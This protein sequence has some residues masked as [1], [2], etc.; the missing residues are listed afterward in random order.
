MRGGSRGEGGGGA[1]ENNPLTQACAR[2]IERARGCECTWDSGARGHTC[3]ELTLGIGSHAV[4]NGQDGAGPAVG[5]LA[6][7]AA[8]RRGHARIRVHTGR[9]ARPERVEIAVAVVHVLPDRLPAVHLKCE[10]EPHLICHLPGMAGAQDMGVGGGG[11]WVGVGASVG[12]VMGKSMKRGV[13]RAGAR[14]GAGAEAGVGAA[15]GVRP[16]IGIGAWSVSQS[17]SPPLKIM[18]S[19]ELYAS[20]CLWDICHINNTY[21][22]H[23][24][25]IHA[26]PHMDHVHST[27]TAHVHHTHIHQ[28]TPSCTPQEKA[29]FAHPSLWALGTPKRG[30]IDCNRLKQIRVLRTG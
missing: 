3:P 20:P 24:Y 7:L 6:V 8:H 29:R 12:A 30:E 10:V 17:I 22:P 26:T 28:S 2:G 11:A 19:E 16:E 13:G 14:A 1:C 21:A 9:R 15:V 4:G 27:Y 5:P 18:V 25:H 23:T